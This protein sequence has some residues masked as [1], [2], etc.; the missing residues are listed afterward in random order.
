MSRCECLRVGWWPGRSTEYN[1]RY[2][3]EGDKQD[4]LW[5]TNKGEKCTKTTPGVFLEQ[6][7]ALRLLY[8]GGEIEGGM[9]FGGKI[10]FHL[11]GQWDIQI[12]MSRDESGA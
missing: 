7:R 6:M 8:W 9:H 11:R 2:I 3:L 12:E 1:L 5:A 10:K 4:L